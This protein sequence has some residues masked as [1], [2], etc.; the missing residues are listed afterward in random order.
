MP[1]LP[2]ICWFVS[3]SHHGAQLTRY[4]TV[5]LVD[6]ESDEYAPSS[7]TVFQRCIN[8]TYEQLNSNVEMP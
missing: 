7:T 4:L 6:L 5:L 8:L 3:S 1:S 2:I